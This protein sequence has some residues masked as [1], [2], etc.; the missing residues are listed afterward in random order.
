MD[1]WKRMIAA[2]GGDPDAPLP[3]ATR[4]V[5][6][7][8]GRRRRA[9]RAGRATRSASRRG[10]SVPG[11]ARKED[12][13][14][15]GAGVELHA[16]PGDARAGG[17]AAADAAHRHARSG[18]GGR[19]RRSTAAVVVAPAGHRRAVAAAR[20]R[21]HRR[22]IA[23]RRRADGGTMEPMS[24]VPGSDAW[25]DAGLAPVD[26]DGPRSLA[27]D[28]GRR[29]TTPR[30]TSRG[31]RARTATAGPTRRTW[32]SRTPRCPPTTRMLTPDRRS[33]RIRPGT[34]SP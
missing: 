9:R 32:S 27:D 14:Q 23:S 12:P 25:K 11:R 13:V 30:S 2:Q 1:A 7:A 19:S 31:S 16:K 6:G 24:T 8:R 29:P 15:A 20:D 4:D 5:A 34:V 33:G 10:G 21:P 28:V 18:S 22:L 17:A 26:P 3:V